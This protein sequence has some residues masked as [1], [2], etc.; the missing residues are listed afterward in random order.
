MADRARRWLTGASIVLTMFS[1]GMLAMT[2][3][4]INSALQ[5]LLLIIGGFILARIQLQ[6]GWRLGPYARRR[7][8]V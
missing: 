1:V 3:I 4:F 8:A 7:P 6:F 2:L 5:G